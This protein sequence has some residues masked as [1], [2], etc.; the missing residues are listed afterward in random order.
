MR[1]EITQ[2]LLRELL[3]YEP[4]TGIFTWRQRDKKWFKHEASWKRWNTRYAGKRAGNLV[5]DTEGYQLRQVNVFKKTIAAHRAA[6][7]YM[8]GL[9]IPEEIDHK[10]RDAKD[11]RW[12]NLRASDRSANSKNRSLNR[13][14]RSGFMGVSW[15]SR[16]G[17]WRA[18]CKIDG[19]THSMGYFSDP[20]EAAKVVSEFRA[21]HNF[22]PMHGACM[23]YYAKAAS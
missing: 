8:A 4:D 16:T 19:V 12:E 3:C 23:A 17:K 9:P 1:I 18:T 20:E 7:V 14:S 11:N 2:E 6:W 10:N 13:T 5:T 15:H 21:S 22:D